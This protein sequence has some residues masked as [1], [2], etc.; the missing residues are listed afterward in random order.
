MV[1]TLDAPQG[2]ACNIIWKNISFLFW[3]FGCWGSSAAKLGHELTVH[4]YS[5]HFPAYRNVFV[6]QRLIRQR[7]NS[8]FFFIFSKHTTV[9]NFWARC[10]LLGY[11]KLTV[12]SENHNF[13]FQSLEQGTDISGIV[14]WEQGTACFSHT[15]NNMRYL[16]FHV[17]Y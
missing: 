1:F 14:L 13:V 7:I 5:H 4:I 15:K 9:L 6:D 12:M 8:L 3:P 2:N 10:M 11:G 17:N 16:V